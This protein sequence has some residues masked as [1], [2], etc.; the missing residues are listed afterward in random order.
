MADGGRS[1]SSYHNSQRP[2]IGLFNTQTV[3]LPSVQR[4]SI[5]PSSR[6]IVTDFSGANSTQLPLPS[7]AFSMQRSPSISSV[8]P[9]STN[10]NF[11]DGAKASVQVQRP[12]LSSQLT[13]L[14]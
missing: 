8:Y 3:Q 11:H 7:H 4:T 2:T 1:S 14:C 5:T 9:G 6:P 12:S 13:S 10:I